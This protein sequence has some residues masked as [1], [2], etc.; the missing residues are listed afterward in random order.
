M[1]AIQAFAVS[2]DSPSNAFLQLWLE[3]PDQHPYPE[4]IFNVLFKG[5]LTP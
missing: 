4:V 3:A 2:I 5:L 1:M